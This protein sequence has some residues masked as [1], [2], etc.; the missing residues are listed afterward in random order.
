MD[1]FKEMRYWKL[2]KEAL[3]STQ[4]RTCLEEAT[5]DLQTT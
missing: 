2:K 4:W 3:D 5:M 1:D